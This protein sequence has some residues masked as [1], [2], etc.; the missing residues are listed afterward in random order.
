MRGEKHFSLFLGSPF[1]VLGFFFRCL[2]LCG[3][4]CD[5][6]LPCNLWRDKVRERERKREK[7][8]ERGL[9]MNFNTI[10]SLCFL[11]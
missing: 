1:C 8:R 2:L 10:E 5:M 3:D 4:H 7:E 6:K 9:M 11:C